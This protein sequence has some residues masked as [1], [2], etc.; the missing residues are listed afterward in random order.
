M[1]KSLLL[2]SAFFTII[3]LSAQNIS[4]NG[5]TINTNPAPVNGQITLSFNFNIPINAAAISATPDPIRINITLNKLVPV[6]NSSNEP[7]ISGTGTTATYFTWTYDPSLSAVIGVQNQNIPA[8]ADGTT[9][10]LNAI[11]TQP[12]P[13]TA[14]TAGHGI[15]VNIVPGMVTNNLT[16]D[17][18][19]QVYGYT[20]GAL[21]VAFD[22][23][24][25]AFRGDRFTAKWRTLSETNNKEFRI[26]ISQD[27]TTFQPIGTVASLAKE[28]NS[29]TK[30]EYSFS[31]SWEEMRAELGYSLIGMLLLGSIMAM[32]L[33]KKRRFMVLGIAGSLMM[34][35]FF[36][37]CRKKDRQEIATKPDIFFRVAQ[38]DIDN[39]TH[40]SKTVKVMAE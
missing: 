4:V 33:I 24:E 3:S 14:G 20:E 38:I 23:V 5:A 35:T 25:G 10:S 40:Y 1:K 12:S 37:A 11:I 6:L 18:D 9:I 32:A 19:V 16:T 39:S 8:N 17:D 31:K 21:P 22:Y 7:E 36:L 28:G 30:L 27:G 15:N 13:A 26:E 34:A 29:D 2:I